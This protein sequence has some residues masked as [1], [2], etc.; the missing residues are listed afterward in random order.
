MQF[1]DCMQSIEVVM[2]WCSAESQNVSYLTCG[3]AV[4]VLKAAEIHELLLL[5][6]KTTHDGW[7]TVSCQLVKLLASGRCPCQPLPVNFTSCSHQLHLTILL[8][9]MCR[10]Q[11]RRQIESSNTLAGG[12][13]MSHPPS[14]LPLL[15][16]C[17][18]NHYAWTCLCTSHQLSGK[19]S[20]DSRNSPCTCKLQLSCIKAAFPVA[21][22]H[23]GC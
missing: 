14:W 4:S 15:I 23:P 10:G 20:L 3:P 12:I 2:S 1:S 5:L 7:K 6:S 9:V 21:T 19:C 13:R 16:I 17:N 22:G 8:A 11:G 18:E